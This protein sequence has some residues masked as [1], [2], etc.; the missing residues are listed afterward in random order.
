MKRSRSPRA[1]RGSG[2]VKEALGEEKSFQWRY[3]HTLAGFPLPF[4][5]RK[6]IQEEEE[7]KRT[8][9]SGEK[10][11]LKRLVENVNTVPLAL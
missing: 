8:T 6:L 2:H 3:V 9:S 7:A 11:S 10:N 5:F 1:R 4:S